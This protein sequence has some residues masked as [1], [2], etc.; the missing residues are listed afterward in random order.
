[1]TT[2]I[3]LLDE[4]VINRIAAGESVSR[5]AAIMKELLE[6]ALDAGS[7]R[8]DMSISAGGKSLILVQDNG[9]GMSEDDLRL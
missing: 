3:R 4:N 8:I 9:D 7:T 6:N 5:P 1:M 2:K